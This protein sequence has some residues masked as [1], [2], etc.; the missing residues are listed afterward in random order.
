MES[1]LTPLQRRLLVVLRGLGW[2][3]TGGA[4]L[5]G[6]HLGHR[7][8]RD[9]D[10]F[11]HGRRTLDHLPLE[12]ESRLT[13][14]GLTWRRL[15]TAEAFCKIQVSDGEESLPID[16]VAEPV[17][18]VEPPV[19][20]E[21]GLFVDGIQEILTNKLTALLSRWEQRD[22]V[23]VHAL[24]GAGADLERA[25]RDAPRK[26]GGFSPPTLAW[27]LDTMPVGEFP[28]ELV[29]YRDELVLRLLT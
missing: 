3:L 5:V 28:P 19:E 17:P 24:L 22:L 15:V 7:T 6:Y 29:A 21:E 18:W 12:V 8:T 26:D 11:W 9:L 20:V 14:A 4:A 27:V 16:L 25:L 23:D 13:R 2:T 1:R 10:L